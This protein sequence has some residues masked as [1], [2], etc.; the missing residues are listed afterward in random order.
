MREVLKKLRTLWKRRQ[1]EKDLEDELAFHLA[2]REEKKGE[3]ER[4]AFGNVALV[5]EDLRDQWT[6][7]AIEN[8]WRDLRYAARMLQRSPGF[9][10]V[11]ILSLAIG[12]GANTAIFSVVDAIL[13]K[14]L[15]VR[16]PKQLRLV[17]WTGEPRI[18]FHSSSG[19]TTNLRGM[20]V[21]G[22][23]PYPIYKLLTTSVPQFSDVMGFIYSEVTVTEVGASHYGN[24]HFVTGNFFGGL[25]AR[26]ETDCFHAAAKIA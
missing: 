7:R 2:M 5:K 15:P 8:F 26:G 6:F 9:T 25:A 23:F 16:D 14:S 22:Q 10:L 11:A 17:L 18:P 20:K 13:L 3:G 19:Y 12:I 21:H 1:L 4:R 24:A